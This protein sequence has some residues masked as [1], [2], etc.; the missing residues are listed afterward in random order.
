MSDSNSCDKKAAKPHGLRDTLALDWLCAEWQKN[1]SQAH[2]EK[3]LE[4]SV[5]QGHPQRDILL[6]LLCC[7]VVDKVIVRTDGNGCYTVQLCII[8]S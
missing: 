8:I 7:L 1:Y 4:G 6:P 5:A 3:T 2:K